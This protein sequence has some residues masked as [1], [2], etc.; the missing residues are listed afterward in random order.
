MSTHHSVRLERFARSPLAACLAASF[1]FALASASA[2]EPARTHETSPHASAPPSPSGAANAHAEKRH[3]ARQVTSPH[4]VTSCAD[5]STQGT[6]RYEVANAFDGDMIDMS[7][8]P[9]SVITLDSSQVPTPIQILQNTLYLKGPAAGA[10]Y[11]TISGGTQSAVLQHLGAG[12]LYITDLTVADGTNFT[13]TGP[14]GGCI[15]SSGNVSLSRSVVSHCEVGSSTQHPRGGGIF[16]NGNL[17]LSASTI[18][19]SRAVGV[20]HYARGGGAFVIGTFSALGST[21]SDNV[22]VS[23]YSDHSSQAGGIAAFGVA[24]VKGSTISGNVA[25]YTGGFYTLLGGTISNSTISDNT[26]TLAF[27]GTYT[28]GPL[29]VDNA[30]IAFNTAGANF[31]GAGLYSYNALALK[32]SI[33]ADNR[34]ADG[35]SDLGG[36]QGIVVPS[37]DH[38][39]ITSSTLPPINGTVTACPQLDPLADTG[40]GIKTHALRHTSPA[41]DVGSN[42]TGL[43]SDERLFDRSWG[44]DV[45]IG[46]VER[47]SSDFDDR[48]TAGGFD[49]VCDQ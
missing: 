12:T 9:C 22:A 7:A 46:S 17:S 10:S 44:A 15:S 18:S 41:I 42:P 30:T 11:L 36:A 20:N 43:L 45:D 4:F 26:A 2:G 19:D 49:G 32:S 48:I 5:D 39:L 27:G 28:R 24:T 21:I 16:T 34:N 23:K 37:G 38:N 40:G 33:I 29:E 31:S 13:N 8:A 35:S 25:D 47:R 14:D 1:G 3:A 6:L